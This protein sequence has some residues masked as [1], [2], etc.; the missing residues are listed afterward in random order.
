MYTYYLKFSRDD[1]EDRKNWG[2]ESEKSLI[3]QISEEEKFWWNEGATVK[4]VFTSFQFNR[5]L[6]NSEM[7]NDGV[8]ARIG[9]LSSRGIRRN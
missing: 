6:L 1:D 3:D 5:A 9:A 2:N 4:S 7:I 8:A